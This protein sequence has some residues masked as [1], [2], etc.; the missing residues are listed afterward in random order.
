MLKHSLKALFISVL[1]VSLTA[2]LG[3]GSLNY[4]Q[5]KML[6]KQG[7][8][9]TEEGWSLGLPERLLFNFDQAN[10]SDKNRQQVEIL[11]HQLQKYNLKKVR[12]V[13]HT[14]SIGN[15]EY[16]LKLSEKRALSVTEIFLENGFKSSDIKTVGRGSTQP[17]NSA[18]TDEAHAENRRVA[19]IIIP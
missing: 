14:D 13:G 9:L 6:K 5:V 11:A 3:M 1:L 2:C 15:P 16:N 10:I 8:V 4:K 7:F 19:V 12:I 18:N 17:I